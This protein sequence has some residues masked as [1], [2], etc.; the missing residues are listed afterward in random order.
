MA[1]PEQESLR[2]IIQAANSFEVLIWAAVWGSAV[3]IL[4]AV[5]QRVL[6]LGQAIGAWVQGSKSMILAILVLILAWTLKDICGDINT[7]KFIFKSFC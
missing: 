4:L 7:N 5:L 3:A 1:H 2:H 6:N